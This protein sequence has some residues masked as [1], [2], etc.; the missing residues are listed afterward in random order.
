[1]SY[2]T[3][4]F[5]KKKKENSCPSLNVFIKSFP[6]KIRQQNWKIKQNKHGIR[7]SMAETAAA[8]M[9]I[10]KLNWNRCFKMRN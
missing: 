1:M 4:V 8:N 7:Q 10:R 2:C 5:K 6:P 3:R 9:I